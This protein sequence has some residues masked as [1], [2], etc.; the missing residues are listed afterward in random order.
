MYRDDESPRRVERCG[1]RRFNGDSVSV[2]DQLRAAAQNF[3]H[4]ERDFVVA[5]ESAR[6]G[7]VATVKPKCTRAGIERIRAKRI[8]E[9]REQIITPRDV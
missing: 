4:R 3:V 2:D 8:L 6:G 5:F 9:T 1:L 7:D